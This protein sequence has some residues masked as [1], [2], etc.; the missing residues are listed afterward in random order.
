M[1]ECATYWHMNHVR[2]DLPSA[3]MVF[4]TDALHPETYKGPDHY[5]GAACASVA[6]PPHR[7][8]PAARVSLADRCLCAELAACASIIDP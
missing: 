1:D 4:R 3:R 2:R 7:A 8:R 5:E 6:D